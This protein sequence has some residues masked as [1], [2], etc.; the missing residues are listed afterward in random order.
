MDILKRKMHAFGGYN[1]SSRL[2]GFAESTQAY[3][4]SRL[5]DAI[6]STRRRKLVDSVIQLSRLD[7]TDNSNARYKRGGI[8]LLLHHLF[9]PK[10][11]KYLSIRG[12]LHYLS[13]CFALRHYHFNSINSIGNFRYI[14]FI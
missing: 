1:F 7:F 8:G 6:K 10:L 3:S 2:D 4:M 12:H 13:D 14:Y 9:Y 5:G 11:F